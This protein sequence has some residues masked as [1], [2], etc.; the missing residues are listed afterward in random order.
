MAEQSLLEGG[1]SVQVMPVPSA[2]REGCGFCLRLSPDDLKRAAV[3]LSE[4]EISLTEAYIPE[5]NQDLKGTS[6]SY[7]KIS[8]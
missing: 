5:E 1:F 8:I 6:V 7:K 2:I 4:R 3:F